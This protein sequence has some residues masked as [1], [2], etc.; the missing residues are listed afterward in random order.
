[1]SDPLPPRPEEIIPEQSDL[2]IEY[3]TMTALD[4]DEYQRLSNDI[5]EN[6]VFEPVIVDE[7]NC[8]IDGHHREALAQWHDL[9]GSNAPDYVTVGDLDND[10]KLARGTKQNVIGRDT[11]DSVKSHA[12]KQYIE[13][14]WDRTDDGDLIRPET[15]KQI[16]KK[17]G[18]S[19]DTVGGVLKNSTGRIILHERLKAADYYE[20]NP[21]ASYREVARQV[22]SSHTKVTEWLKEDFDESDETDDEQET[23]S[24][25]TFSKQPER[26]A[27]TS[28]DAV[29]VTKEGGEDGTS[30]DGSEGDKLRDLEVLTSQQTDEW[31][32]P[33]E[34]VE[35]LADDVGGFDLDPCSGA[36]SS[37][38]AESVYTEADDGLKQEW[39]GTVWVNPPYSEMWDWVNKAATEAAAG[40][41][42]SVFFL[43]K[44]DSSTEW[45]QAAHA[46]ASV[47]CAIDH[48]LTFGDSGNSAPFASHIM[49][50]GEVG[51][52][53]TLQEL[54][55]L[56]KPGYES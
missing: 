2:T 8:I 9:T 12:V 17:L 47:I 31:S 54:G 34:V 56:L 36:E 3:Q 51:G 45:W 28:A 11:T 4:P 5:R 32:S 39:F 13:T 22:D 37:P 52:L 10:E 19:D 53:E 29:G 27:E 55:G 26:A 35:P 48:R 50:F 42:D 23:T 25:D 33:R 14:A 41:A 24:S 44:G 43:C 18:V 6:G 7:E 46:S 40:E 49:L 38:F 30:T 15:N 20:E 16:A 21:Q 1:M